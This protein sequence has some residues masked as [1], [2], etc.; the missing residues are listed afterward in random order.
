MAAYSPSAATPT[1]TR[2]INMCRD[3]DLTHRPSH[4]S[5][6]ETSAALCRAPCL[7]RYDYSFR[8]HDFEGASFNILNQYEYLAQKGPHLAP[9]LD[10]FSRMAAMLQRVLVAAWSAGSRRTAMH[11]TTSFSAHRRGHAGFAR[12]RFGPAAP[13]RQHRASI[14][15][16]IA[17]HV[18]AAAGPRPAY[19]GVYQ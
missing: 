11:P 18:F 2:K 3:R 10:S 14:T 13:T 12:T 8:L 15:W 16:M 6:P 1:Q 4:L 5:T 7:K 17:C 19:A 9:F